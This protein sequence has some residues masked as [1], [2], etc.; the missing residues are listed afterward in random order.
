MVRGKAT[1]CSGWKVQSG[2]Q[3]PVQAKEV[4]VGDGILAERPF[5]ISQSLICDAINLLRMLDAALACGMQ[6]G[7]D[8][9]HPRDGMR[10]TFRIVQ[11]QKLRVR[12]GPREIKQNRSH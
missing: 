5:P 6:C 9:R 12:K 3:P 8:E 10:F 4:N 2:L 7:R 1:E 11:R